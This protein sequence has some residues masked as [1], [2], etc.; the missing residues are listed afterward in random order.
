MRMKREEKRSWQKGRHKPGWRGAGGEQGGMCFH[1]WSQLHCLITLWGGHFHCILQ[2]TKWSL[3]EPCPQTHSWLPEPRLAPWPT[4]LQISDLPPQPT[5]FLHIQ[6]LLN[7]LFC[8]QVLTPCS[9][10]ELGSRFW[11]HRV[12]HGET[13]QAETPTQ[14]LKLTINRWTPTRQ[15]SGGG[16]SRAGPTFSTESIMPPLRLT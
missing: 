13:R 15:L 3:K 11:Q 10:G 14:M 12:G 6:S 7:C 4:W 5:D 9:S 2:I 1:S 8:A 16:F